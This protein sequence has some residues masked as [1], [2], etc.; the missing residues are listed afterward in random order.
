MSGF[1]ALWTPADPPVRVSYGEQDV[2]ESFGGQASDSGTYKEANYVFNVEN[3]HDTYNGGTGLELLY[4][5]GTIITGVAVQ[6]VDGAAAGD[7]VMTLS[8]GVNTPAAVTT[9][10]APLGEGDW[11]VATVAATAITGTN[12]MEMLFSGLTAGTIRVVVTYLDNANRPG[13]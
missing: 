9:V 12:T 1:E 5:P 3:M 10:T 8:D 7:I 11:A 6:D 4:P 2:N 13:R